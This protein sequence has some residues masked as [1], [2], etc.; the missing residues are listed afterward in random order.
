MRYLGMSRGTWQ[1]QAHP[2]AWDYRVE[3]PGFR[4]HLSD[5]HAAIGLAQLSRLPEFAARRRRLAATYDAALGSLSG[6]LPIRRDLLG[7]IPN[8]YI[9]RVINGRRDALYE[10]LRE[11]G[12]LCGVHYPPNHRQPAFRVYARPL[13]ATEQV[14]GELLSLPLHTRLTEADIE[15]VATEIRRGLQTDSGMRRSHLAAV[16]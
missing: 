13:P 11:A 6:L 16:G 5:V 9:V 4:Y 2:R 1:R 8:L 14:A 10:R 3:G 12:I 15:R 7:T